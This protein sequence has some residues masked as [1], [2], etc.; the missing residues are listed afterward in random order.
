MSLAASTTHEKPSPN[1]SATVSSQST[2]RSRPSSPAGIRQRKLAPETS[3]QQGENSSAERTAM[4]SAQRSPEVIFQGLRATKRPLFKAVRGVLLRWLVTASVAASMAVVI[5]VYSSKPVMSQEE[6]R[7]FNA[8][9]TGL[10]IWLSLAIASSLNGMIG[11]MRWWILSRRYRSRRKVELILQAEKMTHLVKL[12]F[13]SRRLS[14]HMAALFWLLVL[15]GTQAGVASLGLCYTNDTAEKHALMVPGNVSIPDM[16]SV[17]TNKIVSDNSTSLGAQQYT[18]NSYGTV[19]IAYTTETMDNIPGPGILWYT[20]D[21]LMFCNDTSRCRYVFHDISTES[22]MTDYTNPVTVTTSRSLDAFSHC[23]SF[24]IKDGGNGTSHNITITRDDG[25]LELT[26]PVASGV[27]QTIFMTN[28][29]DDCGPGCSIVYAVE[30]SDTAP[31]Y[32]EC[33]VTVSQVSNATIKEHQVSSNLTSMVSGSIALQGYEAS[34]LASSN[35]LQFQIYPA[36]SIF[37]TPLNGSVDL[38]S[39]LIARFTIGVVAAT[40]DNN[41]LLFV[42]GIEP[43]I[44]VQLKV[45]HW[46]MIILILILLVSIHLILAM[47][48][49]LL[50]HRVVVPEHSVVEVAKVLRAM[51]NEY[52]PEKY[53]STKGTKAG[54][55]KSKALWIYRDTQV[56]DGVY[57]LHMEEDFRGEE[58]AEQD[59]NICCEVVSEP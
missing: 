30:L 42:A 10:S 59:T 25:H 1:E 9:I 8:I 6:K 43:K 11:D 17:Q 40:A 29:T 2:H 41:E 51:T 50:A 28:F 13:R 24:P 47:S 5:R 22:I 36:E 33:N 15:I 52:H 3:S 44:G 55:C 45:P 4:L 14:I 48:T 37:G 32:Y 34:S 19:S 27:S 21:P 58:K 31:W 57:D 26:V 12:A 35:D 56:V 18:A 39:S 53:N 20:G 54:E 46:D 16:S 23:N 38:M 49:A 7:A